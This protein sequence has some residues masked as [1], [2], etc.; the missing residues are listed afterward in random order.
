[1]DLPALL[2]RYASGTPADRAEVRAVLRRHPSA[3]LPQA[4]TTAAEF[5]QWMLLVSADDQGVDTRDWMLL[6]RDLCTRAAGLG[7]DT[8]P[9]L[10][11]AAALSSDVDRHG[12]GSTRHLLS[13][14]IAAAP[15]PSAQ[16]RDP[17]GNVATVPGHE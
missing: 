7:I 13:A 4:W 9:A 14:L 10:R 5:R 2:E 3:H 16:E 1:M 12:M 11:E 15:G 8:A 17:N 6:V